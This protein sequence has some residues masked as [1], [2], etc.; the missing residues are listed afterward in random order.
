MVLFKR[1]R[2]GINGGRDI[3]IKNDLICCID[4]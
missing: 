3:A 1:K 4:G 2:D